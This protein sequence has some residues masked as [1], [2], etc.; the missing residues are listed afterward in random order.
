MSLL[1]TASSMKDQPCAIF[2][3][4]RRDF[5]KCHLDYPSIAIAAAKRDCDTQQR[6]K[7]AFEKA[8]HFGKLHI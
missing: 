2:K 8:G 7:V 3:Q 5:G 4:F 1:L 6:G